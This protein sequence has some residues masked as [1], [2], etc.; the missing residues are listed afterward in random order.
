VRCRRLRLS[1]RDPS[2]STPALRA[3]GAEI[4]VENWLH[5]RAR[6]VTGAHFA[7]DMVSVTGT[8][9]TDDGGAL[10]RGETVIENAAREPEVCD[11][12]D[13]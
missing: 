3:L 10:A 13:F 6:R 12:A 11:L 5:P 2:T 1:A 4:S 8:G 9:R 7:F